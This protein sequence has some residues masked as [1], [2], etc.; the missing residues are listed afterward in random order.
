MNLQSTHSKFPE[1]M[2]P[3]NYWANYD[4]IIT[5][6]SLVEAAETQSFRSDHKST[7]EYKLNQVTHSNGDF[8]K[9]QNDYTTKESSVVNGTV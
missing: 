8:S 7:I 4:Y 1:G 3:I 6:D 5:F 9:N 2:N